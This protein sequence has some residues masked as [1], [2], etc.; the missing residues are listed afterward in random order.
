MRF[1]EWDAQ[2]QSK[3]AGWV[4]MGTEVKVVC[5]RSATEVDTYSDFNLEYDAATGTV[6][7]IVCSGH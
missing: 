6:R 7:I 5:V 3:I 4:A 2:W 1:Q